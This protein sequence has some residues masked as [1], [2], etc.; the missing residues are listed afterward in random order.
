MAYTLHF[1]L[2]KRQWPL[3]IYFKIQ[4]EKSR[5]LS[6]THFPFITKMPPA[7]LHFPKQKVSLKQA[8]FNSMVTLQQYAKGCWVSRRKAEV[9][10][11]LVFYTVFTLLIF[12]S[13]YSQDDSFEKIHGALQQLPATRGNSRFSAFT[14]LP[15]SPLAFD[16]VRNQRK[17]RKNKCLFLFEVAQNSCPKHL[18]SVLSFSKEHCSDQIDWKQPLCPRTTTLSTALHTNL[19]ALGLACTHTED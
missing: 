4:S 6:L 1:L 2:K 19:L 7:T 8:A 17:V 10:F 11:R 12:T 9:C 18:P 3:P 16:P 15:V 13:L 5:F 14:L